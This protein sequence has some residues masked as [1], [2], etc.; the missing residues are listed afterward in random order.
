MYNYPEHLFPWSDSGTFISDS[1]FTH[2]PQ[3]LHT[4]LL[5]TADICRPKTSLAHSNRA[6]DFAA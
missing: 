5:T 1:E 2:V 4:H 3:H 6:E